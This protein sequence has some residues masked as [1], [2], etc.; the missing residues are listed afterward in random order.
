MRSWLGRKLVQAQ[1][2]LKAWLDK[3]VNVNEKVSHTLMNF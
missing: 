1:N 3:A 2:N